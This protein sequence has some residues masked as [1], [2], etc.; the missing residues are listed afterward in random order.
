MALLDRVDTLLGDIDSSARPN[1]AELQREALESGRAS[2]CMQVD[3]ASRKLMRQGQRE[4]ALELMAIA[5]TAPALPAMIYANLR[6][7]RSPCYVYGGAIQLCLDAGEVDR[8]VAYAMHALPRA[9]E[10]L[11]IYVCAARALMRAGNTERVLEM[12]RLARDAN[13]GDL[14]AFSQDPSFADIAE[15]NE[16]Q[17]ASRPTT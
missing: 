5:L 17:A 14:D 10:Q 8:A 9:E 15:S 4:V 3:I 12:V 1:R 6:E 7:R 13:Y 16:F 2:I 11:D